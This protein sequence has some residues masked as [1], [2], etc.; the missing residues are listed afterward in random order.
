[1]SLCKPR[2]TSILCGHRSHF[3]LW[4]L[5]QRLR[6]DTFVKVVLHKACRQLFSKKLTVKSVKHVRLPS[7]LRT[8]ISHRS[9]VTLEYWLR[10]VCANIQATKASQAS[11]TKLKG[12]Q[13]TALVESGD[14]CRPRF[15]R[16]VLSRGAIRKT[17]WQR[18]HSICAFP[19]SLNCLKVSPSLPL[20]TFPHLSS[21]LDFY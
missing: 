2:G 21:P 17:A 11:K 16:R 9:Y 5:R 10:K 8:T 12:L 3:E 20:I 14:L 13:F 7:V 18:F 1:M 4:D 15:C 19:K 6:E